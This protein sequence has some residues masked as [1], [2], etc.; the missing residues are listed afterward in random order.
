[1]PLDYGPARERL[2]EVATLPYEPGGTSPGSPDWGLD[3]LSVYVC[4]GGE[5]RAVAR[6]ITLDGN[7]FANSRGVNKEPVVG[8][9]Y[10]GLVVEYGSVYAAFLT[11]YETK[12]FRAQVDPQWRGIA[13]LGFRF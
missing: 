1:L 5:D 2:G 4:L 7:T 3:A 10:G 13:T 8:E 11:T 12:T 9:A 6:D